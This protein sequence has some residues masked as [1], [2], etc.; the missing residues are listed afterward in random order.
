MSDIWVVDFKSGPG[1]YDEAK[2]Q[3]CT[4][5]KMWNLFEAEIG[6]GVPRA[7]R[8]GV[9]RLDKVTGMLDDPPIVEV[10]D[11]IE[12]RWNE[13]LHLREYFRTAI[14]PHAKQGRW[15]PHNGKKFATVTT[16][17]DCLN[18]P[19]LPQWAANMTVEYIKEHLPEM[20]DDGQI[21][22]YLKKAKTAYR[23]IGKKA[24][25]IGSIVH[26]AIHCHLSGGKPEP[27]LEGNDQATNSFLAFIQ[28][29]DSVKLK[30]IALEKV[31]IDP[32]HE[33][34][35][36]C[37]FIG[38]AEISPPSSNLSPPSRGGGIF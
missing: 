12:R 7:Q 21:E 27:I 38:Y 22:Y 2:T 17:L 15:Y 6:T 16:V 36:T 32:N 3:V 25:D 31:L 4:Y 9:L 19:A 23:T 35:G 8:A 24:M 20:N 13:F 37:D 26:D 10:T 11:E 5:L 29:A 30:P 14:E 1:V 28:W 33:V 18:K 34:G